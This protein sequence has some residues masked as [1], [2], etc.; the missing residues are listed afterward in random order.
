MERYRL[1]LD[2]NNGART[3]NAS[4][5]LAGA[6]GPAPK[7]KTVLGYVNLGLPS[8]LNLTDDNELDWAETSFD[9]QSVDQEYHSYA[10]GVLTKLD[11]NIL[12]FWEVRLNHPRQLSLHP[13]AHWKRLHRCIG[14]IIRPFLRLQWTIWLSKHRP[15]HVNVHFHLAQRPIQPAVTGS[16]LSSWKLHR[17]L[18]LASGMSRLI[19]QRALSRKSWIWL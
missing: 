5:A 3:G 1:K 14:R 16:A 15:S 10:Y 11:A 17:C 8:N 4:S 13:W 2:A 9:T 7:E 12:K 19:S 6:T 18:N